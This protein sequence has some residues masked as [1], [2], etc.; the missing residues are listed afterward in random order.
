MLLQAK[1]FVENDSLHKTPSS[2]PDKRP[3]AE[4]GEVENPRKAESG[5][6]QPCEHLQTNFDEIGVRTIQFRFQLPPI[7]RLHQRYRRDVY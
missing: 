1:S 4:I 7:V 5:L 2:V 3:A 6:G